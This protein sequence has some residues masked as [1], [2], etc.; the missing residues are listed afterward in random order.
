[1]KGKVLLGLG[2]AALLAMG[3][4]A[5]GQAEILKAKIDFP[6][7]AG[8]KSLPAGEYNF[9]AQEM[10]QVFRVQGMGKDTALVNVITRL[11]AEIHNTPQDAHLVFDKVGDT[12]YLSEIWIPGMDG[13]LVQVTKGA[14]THKVVTI[15]R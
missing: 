14:H 4:M 9:T 1:M 5:M 3:A 10:D 13:F 8:S 7:M 15:Q 11:G 2:V 6:F 12:Y